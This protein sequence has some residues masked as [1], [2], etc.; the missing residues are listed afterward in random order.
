M[1]LLGEVA[2]RAAGG[3]LELAGTDRA[4]VRTVFMH[5]G[6]VD[7]LP[8]PKTDAKKVIRGSALQSFARHGQQLLELRRSP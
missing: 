1:A 3:V 5:Q 6:W 2:P 8:E 7:G 4:V